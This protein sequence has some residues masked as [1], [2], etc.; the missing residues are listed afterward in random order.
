MAQ[1]EVLFPNTA[2]VRPLEIRPGQQ[3]P[4]FNPD[5]TRTHLA[6]MNLVTV[7][8]YLILAY[9]ELPPL[10]LEIHANYDQKIPLR[11]ITPYSF[12]AEYATETEEERAVK[13]SSNPVDLTLSD[14]I[15]KFWKP[16]AHKLHRPEA[17]PPRFQ[18]RYEDILRQLKLQFIFP[19]VAL[20]AQPSNLNQGGI[21]FED[22][23]P[24]AGSHPDISASR[25]WL[26]GSIR[27]PYAEEFF[28]PIQG[29]ID[30]SME[31]KMDAAA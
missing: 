13:T 15:L 14:D 29:R 18:E 25:I 6:P 31:Q 5:Y 17:R 3:F 8:S 16:G 7:I 2:S 12:N 22:F 11:F 1:I 20:Q 21:R 4:A 27:M 26:A 30:L 9:E 10:P 23:S 28:D 19:V 24:V